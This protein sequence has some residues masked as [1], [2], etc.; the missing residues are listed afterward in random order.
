[1]RS[2]R[3]SEAAR[4]YSGNSINERVK[5]QNYM[6]L[7]EGTPYIATKDISYGFLVNYEN[8]V[9]IPHSKSVEFKLA[10]KG[11]VLICA[12]G[13]SAG[14][15]MAII[16]RD[17]FFVNKLFC[18]ECDAQLNSRYLFYY[19]QTSIFQ[20]LFKNSITGII[21][22]VSLEKVRN[23]PIILPLLE[24]QRD[25]VEKLDKAFA[26]IDLLERNLELSEE[27]AN[28]LLQSILSSAF[29]PAVEGNFSANQEVAMTQSFRES[30]IVKIGEVVDLFNGST[31]LKTNKNFWVNGDVPWFTVDDLRKQGKYITHTEKFITQ[32][33]LKE[34]SI[35]LV[36]EN[37]VLLCCTASVGAIA[38]NRIKL[39]TNQQF[40]ALV[41]KDSRQLLVEY[42]YYW[43]LAN[44][45]TLKSLGRA[46]TI[47][48]VSMSKLRDMTIELPTLEKQ[49]EIVD[50]LDSAF[51]Q[52]ELLK[53]QIR[54]KKDFAVTLRQSL[55]SSAFSQENAG[56]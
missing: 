13:G 42:L 30:T 34:S 2:I 26:E 16:D 9:K 19:L 35:S 1:M 17:V 38:I 48:Y 23:L 25:I 45:D 10:K 55:L 53:A 41:V 4:I 6:G 37:A 18:F 12:E 47:D 40:N 20:D 8:G 5:A 22:G 46:T 15:K 54:T 50:K 33:A 39:T 14:R 51:A 56:A 43:F 3:L 24:K 36:P 29:T 44:M 49:K 31:P 27:N 32:K 11:S 7:N 21:G 52:I 28:Q